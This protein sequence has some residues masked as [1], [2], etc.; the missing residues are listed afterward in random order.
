[1]IKPEIHEIFADILAR[2]AMLPPADRDDCV[3][4]DEPLTHDDEC[5]CM[6]CTQYPN[7]KRGRAYP[8]LR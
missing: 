7:H 2:H 4:F 1:M 8:K 3:K 5:D 6:D